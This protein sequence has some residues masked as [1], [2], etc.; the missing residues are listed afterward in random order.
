MRY[1]E[2]SCVAD[3]WAALSAKEPRS[4]TAAGYVKQVQWNVCTPILFLFNIALEA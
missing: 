3:P 2:V 4:T 1:T